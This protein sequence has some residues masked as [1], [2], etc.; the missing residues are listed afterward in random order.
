MA[1]ELGHL[2]ADAN[3]FTW[4]EATSINAAGTAVGW[5]RKFDSLGSYL[6][7]RPLRWDV[8][9]TA[10][11]LQFPFPEPASDNHISISNVAI[12]D[13]GTVL[14]N[15]SEYGALRWDAFGTATVLPILPPPSLPYPRFL[16]S[17]SHA[18]TINGDGD[19]SIRGG[20][21]GG[22][23]SC[24]AVPATSHRNGRSPKQLPRLFKLA[25]PTRAV[26]AVLI[27]VASLHVN[28]LAS[29]PSTPIRWQCPMCANEPH[30]SHT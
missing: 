1:T 8:A 29:V 21:G 10:M 30:R 13:A 25:C 24:M 16:V 27:E 2:G 3:G 11:Q 14:G 17:R 4:S 12:S 22:N 20:L 19:V 9:G 23:C 15:V 18:S 28:P 7:D 6:G 5:A 26:P